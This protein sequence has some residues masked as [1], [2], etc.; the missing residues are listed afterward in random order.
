MSK[1]RDARQSDLLPAA[2]HQIIDMAIRWC[3][4]R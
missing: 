1:P 3:G 4:A 2:L